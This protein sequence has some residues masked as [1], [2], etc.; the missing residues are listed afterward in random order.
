MAYVKII[1]EKADFKHTLLNVL[2]GIQNT[3]VTG[4]QQK[5]VM[6]VGD[7]KTYDLL[8]DIRSEYGRHFKW[9]IPFTGDWHILLN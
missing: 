1:S 4:L 8:Q 2:G 9:L 5:W 3:L 7:A 6:V